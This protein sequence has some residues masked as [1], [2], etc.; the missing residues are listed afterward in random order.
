MIILNIY[1]SF[2]IEFCVDVLI[3]PKMHEVFCRLKQTEEGL[4]LHDGPLAIFI[5]LIVSLNTLM[6]VY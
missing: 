6:V 1:I 3:S 5:L 2:S 4:I